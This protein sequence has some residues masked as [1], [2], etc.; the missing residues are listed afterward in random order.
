MGQGS[1]RDGVTFYPLSASHLAP[2][3]LS[4]G[5]SGT[6]LLATVPTDTVG[7]SVDI[8]KRLRRT[9][10]PSLPWVLGDLDDPPGTTRE[11][12]N[13]ELSLGSLPDTA[14]VSYVCTSTVLGRFDLSGP[15]GSFE[16][17][18]V[19]RIAVRERWFDWGREPA[20]N[21][22]REITLALAPGVGPVRLAASM[23]GYDTPPYGHQPRGFDFQ[24]NLDRVVDAR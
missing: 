5:Q 2:I 7:V 6:Q 3:A 14:Y 1:V 11:L 17:A 8:L 15:A 20:W 18:F 23:L 4:L 12:A 21:G 16:G 19:V 10:E 22:S 13:V 9:L 24:G